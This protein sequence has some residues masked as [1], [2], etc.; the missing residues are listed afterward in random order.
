[1]PSVAEAVNLRTYADPACDDVV[2]IGRF[3]RAERG[4]ARL[5][6]LQHRYRERARAVRGGVLVCLDAESISLA[7]RYQL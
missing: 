5:A 2:V 4:P 3:V 1:M 7:A 6:R